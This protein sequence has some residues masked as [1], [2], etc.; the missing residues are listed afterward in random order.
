[1]KKYLL[2]CLF[3]VPLFLIPSMPVGFALTLRPQILTVEEHEVRL[4]VPEGM[5]VKFMTP[6]ERPRFLAIGPDYELLAGSAGSSV[7]RLRW[8]YTSAETLVNLP[9]RNH[10]VA[11]R[12]GVL[13]VAE[14]AGLHAASYSGLATTLR[15][16]DFSLVTP[17][18]S[19]TGGHWS[20]TVIVAPDLRLYIGI[21]ISGNCSDEYL[22]ESYPFER[23]RGGVY[24]LDESGAGPVLKPYSS[25]LRNPI[26]LAF[27]P[28]TGNLYATNAGPDNLGFDQPPEIFVPLRQGSFHGMP[29]FQYY[30]GAFRSGLCATSPPPR[31]AG[32]AVEPAVTFDARSTPQGVTFF[33]DSRLSPE[34]NGNGLVA[35]HGSWAVAP[36][37]GD[38]SRR[39][40]KIVMVRF[41]GNQPAGVEDVVAGFQRPDG[42]RF[43]RP[44]GIIMGP[45][46]NLYFTSD[47]GEVTGLFK[48]SRTGGAETLHPV[49]SSVYPLL[50]KEEF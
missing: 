23:R 15:P 30:D 36:D 26:G 11:H 25:G 27:Y 24:V 31:P 44:S 22:D 33:T 2:C 48:L 32:E 9:G 40:P 13:Y 46:G 45:D 37:G 20:R 42:S 12:N 16:E 43:A 34:F 21:G 6:M 41:S 35:V 1:M 39:P 50:M 8:P 19:L 17:L 29:W 47:G 28:A 18:P 5:Q 7:Y 4:M 10:S 38:E 3:L 14:T 49:L